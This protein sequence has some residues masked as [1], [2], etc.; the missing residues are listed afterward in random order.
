GEAARLRQA[1]CGSIGAD[2]M[3]L[4]HPD[5]RRFIIER[6]EGTSP[7]VDQ[8][9]LLRRLAEADLFERFLHARYVGTKR[10]S[11]E[12]AASLIPLLDAVLDA[13]AEGGAEIVLIGM[14]HRGR[15]NV[16]A[17]VVGTPP[18]H[19]FA[20]F[21]DIEPES[22]MGSGD[23][24]YHLGAT[25]T[26]RCA[27]GQDVRVHLVSNASHL[28]AVDPVMMGRARARQDRLGPEGRRKVL[29][30]CLHGD[31][32]FAGQ[33]IAAETLNLDTLAGF[34]VGGTVQVIV[35]NLIGFTTAPR[36]LHS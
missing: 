5:S 25:G 16:M 4:P 28:E 20:A 8:R 26:H 34:G 1:Y 13:A 19:L 29:P 15:L 14:S 23:V 32:A 2:F 33:G 9:P 10:Y 31:A 18:S 21:Q 6:M 11:L 7:P 35:N 12:G 22:V 36:A 24:R 27:S 3:R 17:H 30:L